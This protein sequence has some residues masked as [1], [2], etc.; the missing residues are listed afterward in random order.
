[1]GPPRNFEN[2]VM[3]PQRRYDT[4]SEREREM[5]EDQQEMDDAEHAKGDAQL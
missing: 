2:A 1:M 4:I 5:N 3:R